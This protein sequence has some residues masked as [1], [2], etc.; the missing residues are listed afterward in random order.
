M[1]ST[2][3]DLLRD[4]FAV[5]RSPSRSGGLRESRTLGVCQLKPPA[6][7]SQGCKKGKGPV[8]GLAL[9]PSPVVTT[10]GPLSY[11]VGGGSCKLS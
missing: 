2:K 5:C 8:S 10:S 9:G 3:R 11:L 1:T 7:S 6:R 4:G